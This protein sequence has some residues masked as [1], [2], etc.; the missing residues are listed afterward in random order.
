VKEPALAH[1]KELD[2][3]I[4]ELEDMKRTLET[5]ANHCH[6]DDRPECPILKKPRKDGE[7]VCVTARQARGSAIV[8]SELRGKQETQIKSTLLLMSAGGNISAYSSLVRFILRPDFADVSSKGGANE[9]D[10]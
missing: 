9:S 6:G 3:R 5:L 1:V 8:S 7:R 4:R 2:E 10:T